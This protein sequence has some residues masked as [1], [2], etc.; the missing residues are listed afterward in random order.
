ML[1]GQTTPVDCP[2]LWAAFWLVAREIIGNNLLAMTSA[3]SLKRTTS[4][5]YAFPLENLHW[6]A[7]S[8]VALFT[9]ESSGYQ[10][11]VAL[12]LIKNGD[13]CWPLFLRSNHVFNKLKFVGDD[14]QSSLDKRL[15]TCNCIK[16]QT[17]SRFCSN[18]RLRLSHST[19]SE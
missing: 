1:L 13:F 11:L 7:R 16:F 6:T 14:R 17:I 3:G 15:L 4:W 9:E 10:I 2:T 19:C 12:S 5:L 18:I 8:S